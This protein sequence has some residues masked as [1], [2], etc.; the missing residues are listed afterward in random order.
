M[1]QEETE[2]EQAAKSMTEKQFIAWY[3]EQAYIKEFGEFKG[4]ETERRIWPQLISDTA[5]NAIDA[6]D[7]I[8]NPDLYK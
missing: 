2:M 7:E 4:M 8:R 3:I 1:P 6:Y 5:N